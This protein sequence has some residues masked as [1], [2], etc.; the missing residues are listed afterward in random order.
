MPARIAAVLI[1]YLLYRWV[2]DDRIVPG[3]MVGAGFIL[4]AWLAIDSFTR[5]RHERLQLLEVGSAV[6]G[7]GLLGVGAYLA[8]R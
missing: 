5:P 1:G 7:L 2:W 6:L 3:L 8:L 4:V